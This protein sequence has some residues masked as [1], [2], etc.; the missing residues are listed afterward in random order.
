[1]GA[2]SAR[3]RGEGLDAVEKVVD[4]GFRGGRTTLDDETPCSCGFSDAAQAHGPA[5][6]TADRVVEPA[7][8]RRGVFGVGDGAA[9]VEFELRGQ[10]L[11]QFGIEGHR[12]LAGFTHFVDRRG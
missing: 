11:R 8:Q 3:V 7:P 12:R 2:A 9:Y 4:D 10:G 6:P 5:M 1:L